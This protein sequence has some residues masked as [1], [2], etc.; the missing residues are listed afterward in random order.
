MAFAQVK[1]RFP[2]DT[3]FPC[4]PI[5]S[6]NQHGLIYPLQGESWC[7]GPELVV[8]LAMGATIAVINGYRVDWIAGRANP[9]VTFSRKIA[10]GRKAAKA[11]GNAM[12]E[13]CFKLL[14]NTLYGKVSQ[15][16]SS[17]RPIA[18]DV[19]EHRVFDSESGE[20]TDLPPCSITCP[21]VGAWITSFVRATMVE[22]LHRLP[23]TAI[24][25][26]ATTDGILFVG[27]ESD[28]DTSGPV[29]QAFRRA[30]SLVTGDVNPQIWVV[31]HRLPRALAF[32]TRGLISVVPEDWAG[33]VHLAKAGARLPDYLQTDVERTRFAEKLYRERNYDTKF[34]RRN[35]TSLSEQYRKECDLTS[36]TVM[37]KLSWDYDWKNEPRRAGR[38]C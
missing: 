37:V 5:R 13:L 6:S 26:Q 27:E 38:R 10:E 33:D 15:G 17:K 11:S 28:I 18:D 3:K 4:L 1:F 32:K 31:K 25:L 24:A 35:L 19:E 8:A 12:L 22:A 7:C 2:P 36:K 30:L 23:P 34:E 9:F 20:M 14:G 21:A 16:V 29:A